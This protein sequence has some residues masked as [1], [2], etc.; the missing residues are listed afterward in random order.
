MIVDPYKR[1]PVPPTVGLLT[2]QGVVVDEN[3]DTWKPGFT[4]KGIRVWC[5][6]DVARGLLKEGKG[7]ALCWNGEEIRWRHSR[8]DVEGWTNRHTDVAV[9]KVPFPEDP[10]RALRALK[11]WRS[12][13]AQHGAAPTGTTGSAA[14]SLLKATIDQRLVCSV[15]ERPPLRQT[16][17]GRQQLGPAGQGRFDGPVEQWDMP[18][19]YASTIGGLRYGGRWWRLSE[20]PVSHEPA[21]WAQSG[22]IV[23]V[24]AKVRVGD[25]ALGPLIRRPRRRTS[26]MGLYLDQLVN[27]RYPRDTTIQGLWTWPELEAAVETGAA[28]IL[29]VREGYVHLGGSLRFERWWLAIQDGRAMRGLA[30]QLAKM[31][32][33]ALW[34]R[35]CMD[36]AVQGTRTIRSKQTGRKGLRQRPAERSRRG[37]PLPAHDLAE[38]VSGMVRARLYRAMVAA[39]DRLLSAHTDGVWTR[40]LGLELEGEWRR[41][42]TARRLDLIDPQTLRYWPRRGEPEIVMSGRTTSEAPAAFES[43]WER[44]GHAVPV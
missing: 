26:I 2:D 10:R 43:Q 37:Q 35:F 6:Y 18:A 15:G 28:R 44:L 31:T 25:V 19:A 20:M 11:E 34:G 16:M 17:G 23:F 36:V 41:K 39:G 21:W 30:G 32:G 33:N 9:L 22:R 12:W 13:L 40:E 14:M 5:S 4:P 27:E 8:L 38:A 24:E 1:T 29:S 3:G 42:M 7:E